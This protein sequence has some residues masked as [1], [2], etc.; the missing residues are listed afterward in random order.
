MATVKGQLGATDVPGTGT[1]TDVYTVPALKEASVNV[2]VA[3]RA[4]T[5]TLL[6]VAHIKAGVAAAVAN[7]DYLM[8]DLSTIDLASHTAPLKLTAI[9]MSAGDTIAVYSSASAVS[10]QVNGIEGDAP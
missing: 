8:Y 1:L 10:V 4:A 6:R 9:T 3:N 7:E 5:T 2:T